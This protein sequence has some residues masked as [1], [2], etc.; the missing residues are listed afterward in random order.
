[1]WNH[2]SLNDAAAAAQLLGLMSTI[3]STCYESGAAVNTIHLFNLG[4][5]Q[6]I[7]KLQKTIRKMN[8]DIASSKDIRIKGV[9][10]IKAQFSDQTIKLR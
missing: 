4:T 9:G 2:V 1:M 7:R 3:I 5:L 8:H 6:N 10:K